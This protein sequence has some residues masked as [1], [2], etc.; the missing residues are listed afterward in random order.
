M[1]Y[2]QVQYVF[3]LRVLP[4]AS[5]FPK[6]YKNIQKIA[7]AK[8]STDQFVEPSVDGDVADKVEDVVVLGGR[9]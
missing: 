5:Q 7:K 9:L 8:S 6:L 4:Y 1:S 2:L 3:A